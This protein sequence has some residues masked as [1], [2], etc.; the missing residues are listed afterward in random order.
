M[1]NISGE[2]LL[3]GYFILSCR[4]KSNWLE[5]NQVKNH[6]GRWREACCCFYKELKHALALTAIPRGVRLLYDL[7]FA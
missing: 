3:F 4:R 7:L 6:Q 2:R 1:K 5:R